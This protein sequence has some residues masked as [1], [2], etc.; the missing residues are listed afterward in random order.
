MLY[1]FIVVFLTHIE[2]SFLSVPPEDIR[3]TGS[4]MFSRCFSVWV[5]NQTLYLKINSFIGNQ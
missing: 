3:K 4:L 5:N 2:P 1:R